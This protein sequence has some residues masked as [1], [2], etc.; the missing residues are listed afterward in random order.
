MKKY[1]LVF[2]LL[3]PSV[4]FSDTFVDAYVSDYGSG[5]KE[6][7]LYLEQTI[8]QDV[9][10]YTSLYS[11]EGYESTYVGVAKMFGD[12]QVGVGV[13]EPKYVDGSGNEVRNIGYSPWFWY[14]NDKWESLVSFEF[15]PN[16][17]DAYYYRGYVHYDVTPYLFLG[18]YSERGFGNGPSIGVKSQNDGFNV[19]AFVAKSAAKYDT[20]E[21]VV[22]NMSLSF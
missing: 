1:L 21:V 17:R 19:R 8:T 11:G 14:V 15:L 12:L 7:Y 6:K 10:M 2:L 16:D 18:M 13:A 9:S 22:L 5:F 3:V 20:N 4:S